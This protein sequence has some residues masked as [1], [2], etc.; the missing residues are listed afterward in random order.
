MILKIIQTL[1]RQS[2]RIGSQMKVV[3]AVN[4]TKSE[5][6][7]VRSFSL[8]SRFVIITL[9]AV[10][11]YF[12]FLAIVSHYNV[13]HAN[14][15][16]RIDTPVVAVVDDKIYLQVAVSGEEAVKFRALRDD[17]WPSGVSQCGADVFVRETTSNQ[18]S[19]DA[20]NDSFNGQYW[21]FAINED[22]HDRR[23]CFEAVGESAGALYILSEPVFIDDTQVASFQYKLLAVNGQRAKVSVVTDD[24]IIGWKVFAV[25]DFSVCQNQSYEVSD[26]VYS[27][28]G[29]EKS[30]D[31]T[32]RDDLNYC[33]WAMRE[34]DYLLT[35]TYYIPGPVLHEHRL[36]RTLTANYSIAVRDGQLTVSLEEPD[37][38]GWRIIKVSSDAECTADNLSSRDKLIDTNTRAQSISFAYEE[39]VSYC[40]QAKRQT[41]N[42]HFIFRYIAADTIR[43]LRVDPEDITTTFSSQ[44][45]AGN[46]ITIILQEG[47]ALSWKVIAVENQTDCNEKEAFDNPLVLQKSDSASVTIQYDPNKNYCF[48][49]VRATDDI[50]FTYVYVDRAD[51][52]NIPAPTTNQPVTVTPGPDLGVISVDE[53]APVI[54]FNLNDGLL[55]A[56]A[57][58]AVAFWSYVILVENEACDEFSF[59]GGSDGTVNQINLPE[60]LSEAGVYCFRAT[61]VAGND[62][63]ERYQ[64]V[65]PEPEPEPEPEPDPEPE[66][67]EKEKAESK[68]EDDP[69]KEEAE[70]DS[71]RQLFILIGIGAAVIV[72]FGITLYVIN[73]KNRTIRF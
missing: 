60:D 25:S 5:G 12:A 39:G 65:A 21:N 48:W 9:L 64:I 50:E 18:Y 70:S 2:R 7:R 13:L 14:S 4:A 43:S 66:K 24:E 28:I 8:N 16:W 34:H 62:G 17:H 58:E 15:H 47:D 37:V 31:F 38:L 68:T 36:R 51:L 53:K 45:Q 10:L 1:S 52:N 23:Y 73:S 56:E 20:G 30:I 49:P 61:D 69:V 72:A 63:Y 3:K 55:V 33:F 27:V 67:P 32:Y 46:I 6:V 29:S 41:D 59:E 57:D 40:A 19:I 42:L 22:D 11:L 26:E 44:T 54:E 35:V 71:N